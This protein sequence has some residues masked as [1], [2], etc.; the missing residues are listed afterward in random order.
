MQILV[1]IFDVLWL[2]SVPVLLGLLYRQVAGYISRMEQTML[3][4]RAVSAEAAKK[5]AEAAATL[6]QMLQ[7]ERGGHAT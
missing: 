5:S 6:A 7:D 4:S 3:S 1:T 2:I